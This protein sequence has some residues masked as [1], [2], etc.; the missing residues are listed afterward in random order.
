MKKIECVFLDGNLRSHSE[1]WYR[2]KTRLRVYESHYKHWMR[3]S[4]CNGLSVLIMWFINK[5][6]CF[7]AITKQKL[8]FF[9]P[10][11]FLKETFWNYFIFISYFCSILSRGNSSKTAHYE[12]QR[13]GDTWHNA[14]LL[15]NGRRQC[16]RVVVLII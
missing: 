2:D 13:G 10:L 3:R 8:Y 4:F 12:L 11:Y 16:G 5:Q 7:I 9:Y 15:A 14:L 1:L 6:E